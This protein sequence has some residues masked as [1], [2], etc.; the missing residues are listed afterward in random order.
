M[1]D[2]G[3]LNHVLGDDPQPCWHCGEPTQWLEL[4]FETPLHPGGCT[5]A[6]WREYDEANREAIAQHE[7]DQAD[8]PVGTRRTE[9]GLTVEWT[10]A[11]WRH[12]PRSEIDADQW[13]ASRE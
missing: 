5:D 6:K 9:N 13:R 10:G 4:S 2:D 12:V 11:A 7:R 3:T 1:P 8:T